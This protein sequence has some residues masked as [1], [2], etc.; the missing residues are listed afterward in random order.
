MEL[1]GGI[2]DVLHHVHHAV[3]GHQVVVW[4]VHRVDVDGVVHL[5][6]TPQAS[7]TFHRPF[8]SGKK[9]WDLAPEK[10]C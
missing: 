6:T 4:H 7:F 1:T 5:G 10:I 2:K 8:K 3:G 9:G